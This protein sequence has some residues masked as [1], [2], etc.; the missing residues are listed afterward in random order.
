ML[1]TSIILFAITAVLGIIIISKLLT[2][3]ETPKPVVFLHGAVA[4]TALI[5][6]IIYAVNSDNSPIVS[7]V[8]FVIAALGGFILLAR[9]LSKK[10]G[11]KGLALIHAG[12]AVVA[13]VILLIFAFGL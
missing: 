4:A 5:L 12:A 11:P 1:T 2:N 8:L 9:D 13:F 10:P 6:L 3:K 7:I